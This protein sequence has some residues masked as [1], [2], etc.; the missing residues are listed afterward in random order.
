MTTIYQLL[1]SATDYLS[2]FRLDS[3]REDVELIAFCDVD[4]G[5]LSARA[6]E[7][8]VSRTY[9]EY[10]ALLDAEEIDA[11][12]VCVPPFAHGSIEE[13]V[14][15]KGAALFVEKPVELRMDAAL[16][17]LQAIEDAGIL[18][19]VGYCVRYMD[20]V[21][22]VKERLAGHQVELA[23]GYYMGGAPGNWWRDVS[24]SGGQLVEQT[25]HI[26]DL[27]RYV[28]GEVAAVGGAFVMRDPVEN[29]DVENASVATLYFENGAIGTITSSCMLHRGFKTG[30]DVLAKD[31][32]VEYDYGNLRIDDN[33]QVEEMEPGNN[34]MVAEDAAFI[35]AVESGD[36]TP[37][38][39][40]YRDA[41]T[42]LEVSLLAREAAE[43]HTI[44]ETTFR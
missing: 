10:R 14:A 17:K 44:L 33:G 35:E 15:A 24:K 16:A 34:M 21:A 30:L 38:R 43:R 11:V 32:V 27:A 5:R 41:V 1:N 39:S 6:E 2:S 13:A 19:S 9:T 3:P 12:F 23:L 36:N 25:T 4:E 26:L 42:T 22:V 8:S 28:V 40:D 18:N 31:F 29:S 20:T 37:I 7:Y